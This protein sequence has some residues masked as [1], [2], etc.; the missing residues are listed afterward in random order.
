MGDEH[1][2]DKILSL[3]LLPSYCLSRIN[4]SRHSLAYILPKSETSI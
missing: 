1:V 2:I 4:E 3:V